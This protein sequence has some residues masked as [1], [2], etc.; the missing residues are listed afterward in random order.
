MGPPLL[1]TTA[2]IGPINHWFFR[3]YEPLGATFPFLIIV[4]QPPA[5]LVFGGGSLVSDLLYTYVV[6]LCSLGLSIVVYRLSPLHPLAQ[7]PGP[8]IGKITQLWTLWQ[9]LQ[10]YKYLYHKSLHDK[11]G[12]Y[13]RIGPNEISV[14]DA[15]AVQKILGGLDKGRYYESGRHKLTPPAIVCLSGEAHAD[16]RRVW[17]RA[18]T[19]ASL[20][21]Y[22][23]LIVKRALELVSRLHGHQHAPIDFVAWIDFFAL[24]LMGDLAFGGKFEM[25]KDGQ[26]SDGLGKR[27][28]WFVKASNVVGQVPWL[29]S[30]LQSIPG[31]DQV[32]REFNSFGQNLAKKRIEN[33]AMGTKDLWYHLADEAGLENEKPSLEN[34]AADGIVALVAAS[35]TV[36]STLCSF[37][38]FILSHPKCYGRL[39]EELDR[40]IADEDPFAAA[41][42]QQ[43]PYLSACLNETLRLHPPLP[44][45]GT[46]QVYPTQPA[47]IIAGKSIP[48][49]TT[50]STPAYSLHRNPDYFFPSPDE[51]LPERWESDS[52]FTRHY[53]SAFLPFSSGPSNCVGQS[54]AKLEMRM[55][56]CILF[57]SF[58]LRFADGFDAK[59]WPSGMQDFFVI[60]RGPL[61][62]KLT[63]RC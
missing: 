34:S 22:E 27:I 12:P 52:Q 17:N 33:V 18:M 46:R 5:V 19:T 16:R 38:W 63:P 50:I 57:K 31:V 55:V 14:I 51:F 58:E 42:R 56:L 3:K 15:P 47:Q 45:N 26:D 8:T 20:K 1:L 59:A 30:T 10:G 7:F 29:I 11:Y 53:V 41:A 37:I 40:I 54:F 36:A 48:S 4:A 39:Q 6:F 25:M 43:L 9:T 24:D 13:V 2:L 62:V 60:T 61:Y 28:R 44:S 21:E 35:D 49:G 23:P 32:V